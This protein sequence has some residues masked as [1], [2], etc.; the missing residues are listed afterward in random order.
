MQT[1]EHA[2]NIDKIFPNY[3]I[4]LCVKTLS[5]IFLYILEIH[6]LCIYTHWDV[7]NVKKK[8]QIG[9]HYV[10]FSA[11]VMWDTVTHPIG[12]MLGNTFSRSDIL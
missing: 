6:S 5:K 10:C 9:L 8:K 12:Y 11:V 3:A 1:C 7:K 2:N 4:Y